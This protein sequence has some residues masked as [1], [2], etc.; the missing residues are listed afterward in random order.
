ML[1]I[2][3][4]TPN[5]SFELELRISLKEIQKFTVPIK[6]FNISEIHEEL[7]QYFILAQEG[8]LDRKK[9]MSHAEC[10]DMQDKFNSF[11]TDAEII[12]FY[13]DELFNKPFYNNEHREIRHKAN[14]EELHKVNK[15]EFK[16]TSITNGSID[17][18]DTSQKF[19][20][21]DEEL[22]E[23]CKSMKRIELWLSSFLKPEQV[24]MYVAIKGLKEKRIRVKD[25]AMKIGEHPNNV[26]KRYNRIKKQVEEKFSSKR[27]IF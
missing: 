11:E 24:D 2:P 7:K 23:E 13:Y 14:K 21:D 3:E 27:P 25:Y 5:Q 12:Q 20:G 15:K 17:F 4:N 10:Q 19:L 18:I 9:Q 22:T 1:E 8:K 16:K 26:S 6:D